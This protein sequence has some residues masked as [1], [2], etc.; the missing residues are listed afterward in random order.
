MVVISRLR[1]RKSLTFFL[2]CTDF[3]I[4]HRVR[5]TTLWSRKAIFWAALCQLVLHSRQIVRWLRTALRPLSGHGR[6]ENSE[7]TTPGRGEYEYRPSSRLA[8]SQP[9]HSGL[10]F[11]F[12]QKGLLVTISASASGGEHRLN[13]FKDS[14]P[15]VRVSF[16]ERF[17]GKIN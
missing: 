15:F 6:L 1:T 2:Q 12:S 17:S 14:K 13:N 5:I 4:A 8:D 11:I 3:L 9:R 16:E 7:K 10:T